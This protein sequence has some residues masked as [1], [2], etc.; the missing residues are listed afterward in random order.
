MEELKVLDYSEAAYDL[1]MQGCANI[2]DISYKVDSK[3]YL[4][5]PRYSKR[6]M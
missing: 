5:S 6:N 4:I 3:I 2:T 1:L